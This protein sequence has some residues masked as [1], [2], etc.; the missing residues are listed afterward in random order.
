[1]FNQTVQIQPQLMSGFIDYHWFFFETLSS[2]IIS[3]VKLQKLNTVPNS[4]VFY[5][6]NHN[7]LCLL[8]CCSVNIIVLSML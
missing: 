8:V 5:P 2:S 4:T 6:Y 3:Y 1:M 7:S